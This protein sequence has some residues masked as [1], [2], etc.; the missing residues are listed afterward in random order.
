MCFTNVNDAI[1]IMQAPAYYN[2]DYAVKDDYT[3]VDFGH[4][5]HR[6]GDNTKGSYYVVLPDGRRQVVSYYV[7]GYSGYVADVKYEG[8]AK[9][10][11]KPAYKAA[12]QPEYK[13]DYKPAYKP[14][15]KPTYKPEY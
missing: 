14:A 4:N 9:Y 2:F 6:D 13:A 8:E 7:D 12:Y 5:E 15:Y 1:S 3:Y 11:H 10:D